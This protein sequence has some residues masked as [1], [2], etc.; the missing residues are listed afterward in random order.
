M[1]ETLIG[2][3]THYYSKIGVAA[4]NLKAPLKT[5]DRIHITGH[6]TNLEQAVES[7]EIEHLKVDSAEAGDDVAISIVDKVRDG[8]QVYRQTETA[9]T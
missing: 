4:L 5:G 9:E 2:Q 3:V 1:P 8:D 6:T 7:I